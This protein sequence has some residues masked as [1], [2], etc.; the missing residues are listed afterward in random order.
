MF[1]RLLL[2]ILFRRRRLNWRKVLS[3]PSRRLNHKR[4]LPILTP[5]RRPHQPRTHAPNDQKKEDLLAKQPLNR[6]ALHRTVPLH[7]LLDLALVLQHLEQLAARE[8]DIA[9]AAVEFAFAAAE[10]GLDLGG[11]LGGVEDLA[12]VAHCVCVRGRFWGESVMEAVSGMRILGEVEEVSLEEV[13]FWS[14]GLFSLQ[15]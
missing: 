14:L 9:G 5:E 15:L 10:V 13:S 3:L 6:K 11:Q 4:T 1:L 2:L 12:R 7:G 8:V